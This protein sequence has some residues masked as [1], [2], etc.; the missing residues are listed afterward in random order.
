MKYSVRAAVTVLTACGCLT[1]AAAD[2]L[3]LAP[4]IVTAS[5]YEKTDLETP[6]TTEVITAEQVETMGAQSA[7]DAMRFATGV[8]YKANTVG[9]TGGS[10]SFAASGAAPWFCLT[11][12]R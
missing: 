3:E 6:A 8:I 5:R 10:F 11:E 12:C 1:A 9:D 2:T 7:L 4:V